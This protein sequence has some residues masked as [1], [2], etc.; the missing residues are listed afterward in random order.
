MGVYKIWVYIRY[1]CIK[2]HLRVIEVI[3]AATEVWGGCIL[4]PSTTKL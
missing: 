4:Q 3:I 2:P 1:G